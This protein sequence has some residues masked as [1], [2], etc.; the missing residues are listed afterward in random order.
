[1]KIEFKKFPIAWRFSNSEKLSYL[2]RGQTY[3]HYIKEPHRDIVIYS[4]DYIECEGEERIIE[5]YKSK[6]ISAVDLIKGKLLIG[7][8]KLG[9]RFRKMVWKFMMGEE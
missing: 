5:K 9:M 3:T 8:M 7:Y 1:M 2:D 4:S 6:R